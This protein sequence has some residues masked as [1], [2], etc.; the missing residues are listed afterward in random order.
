M[1]EKLGVSEG[2]EV[3]VG[4]P[5]RDD[6]Q[7]KLGSNTQ[8]NGQF[9]SSSLDWDEH[10]SYRWTLSYDG[11]G[12]GSYS[13]FEGK[14]KIASRK[15]KGGNGGM[16][17][18]GNAVRLMVRAGAHTRAGDVIS[19]SITTVGSSAVSQTLATGTSGGAS[20]QI[21]Y[22]AGSSLSAGFSLEGNIEVH[23]KRHRHPRRHKLDLA[24]LVNAGKV[25]CS[26]SAQTRVDLAY[27]QP[28]HLD[29]PRTVTDSTQKV[30]WQWDNQDPFGANAANEDPDADG[31]RFTLN[32]RFPGQ[33]FD[34]ETG[35]HYNYYRDYDPS[36]GRY[37]ESDP[38]G[39]TGGINTYAY[40]MSQP[41]LRSDFFGLRSKADS[42]ESPCGAEGGRKYADQFPGWSFTLACKAHDR[43]YGTCRKPKLTCDSEFYKNMKSQCKGLPIGLRL[44]CEEA[45]YEYYTAVFYGGWGAYN[46][47][48]AEACRG[49]GCPSN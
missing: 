34:S 1:P 33:Y 6:L 27:I 45:A 41:L 46:R 38:V 8:V 18:A 39:L 10:K 26:Q 9:V 17:H 12:S 23:V 20:Q 4:E 44:F 48:Q 14:T 37:V 42:S 11:N 5:D 32:L 40:V 30:I 21:A 36:T 31:Q 2:L 15:F 7:W 24:F 19:V 25:S 3:D 47:A 13:V 43:C 28:D 22:F 35:L 16:L 49:P 29:T